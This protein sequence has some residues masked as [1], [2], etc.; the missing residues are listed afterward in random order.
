MEILGGMTSLVTL[1]IR[2]CHRLT[3]YA[4]TAVSH[5]LDTTLAY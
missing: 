1:Q 5:L 2:G 3:P 4:R